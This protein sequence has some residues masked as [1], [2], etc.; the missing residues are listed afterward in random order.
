MSITRNGVNLT[1]MFQSGSGT[2]NDFTGFGSYSTTNLAWERQNPLGITRNGTD[3]GTQF[4][5][6]YVDYTSSQNG[7]TI[8]AG[9]NQL[10]VF[11]LGG[12]E[13]G[14]GGNSGAGGGGYN[15]GITG[16]YGT[17]VSS[18]F[19]RDMNTY[20]VTVGIPGNGG[21]G[22]WYYYNNFPN[23]RLVIIDGQPGNSGTPTVFTIGDTTLT[24]SGGIRGANLFRGINP[25]GY[26]PADRPQFP[27]NGGSGGQGSSF[28]ANPGENGNNGFCRVYYLY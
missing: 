9:V 18:V 22:G 28:T 16:T 5:A 6:K 17:Y 24:G 21:R 3:V 27:I 10:K 11:C 25:T 12:G 19:N 20:N 15:Y 26:P 13:G 8:P 2:L 23:R 7:V 1:D 4:M 14:W